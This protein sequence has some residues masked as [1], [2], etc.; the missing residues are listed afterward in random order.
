M[1]WTYLHNSFRQA[2]LRSWAKTVCS[3]RNMFEYALRFVLFDIQLVFQRKTVFHLLKKL[4]KLFEGFFAGK[5]K[6]ISGTKKC[7]IYRYPQGRF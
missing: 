1:R 7:F 3:L 4:S 5:V 6:V 2:T